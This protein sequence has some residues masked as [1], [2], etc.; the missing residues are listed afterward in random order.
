MKPIFSVIPDSVSESTSSRIPIFIGMGTRQ[1]GRIHDWIS[2][3]LLGR[4]QGEE[5]T[6]QPGIAAKS[7]FLFIIL[8]LSL[9]P[10][11]LVAQNPT[12]QWVKQMGGPSN[13]FGN[14]ITTDVNGNLYTTGSFQ[15][16]VD[17][18]PGTG[19][20]NLTSIGNQDIFIQK[21]DSDGNFVW[22][23]QMG[24]TDLGFGYAITTDANGNILTTGYFKGTV[25]FDPGTGTHSFTSAGND[26]FIQKLDANGAFVWAKQMSGIS[27]EEGN[28]I[29][30]DATGNVYI[31]GSFEGTVDFDPGTGTNELSS[32]GVFDIFVQKLDADGAFVWAKSMGGP[33]FDTGYSLTTDANGNVYTTGAF[34][35]GVDFD[36]GPGTTAFTSAG[37]D[38]IFIQKLDPNGEFIWAKQIGG[39]GDDR[40]FSITL[41]ANGHVYTTGAFEGTADFDPGA[42]T[43]DLTS[44]GSA[45]I[46][47]QKLDA[48]GNLLWVKQMGG[49][50]RDWG[51]S[52]VIDANGNVY[53]TGHFLSRADFDPGAG[54]TQ[55]TSA[56]ASDIFVQKLD[57]NGDFVWA[58]Q[59]GGTD[60]DEGSSLTLDANGNIYTT[61]Y[62]EGTAD[63]DPGVG[64]SFLTSA[65]FI[66]FPDIFIHK[67]STTTVGLSE[68]AL[69]TRFIVY[70]NPTKGTISIEFENAQESVTLRLLSL[71]GQVIMTQRSSYTHILP[72]SFSQPNGVYILEIV[73][74]EAN[75]AVVRLLKE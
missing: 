74:D 13:D 1:Q 51:K 67:L 65:G 31:T 53:S 73:D 30:T 29:T 22:A 4:G 25:D 50:G 39:I 52:L 72:L 42:G 18:D 27:Q 46:F 21:L 63:F 59:M 47:I 37:N 8:L 36:P 70:P 64:T 68:N 11:S 35:G 69:S 6:A 28:S 10:S 40:G 5:Q 71:S 24:G 33:M 57:A 7:S 58:E 9:F 17:F 49:P 45:D 3:F 75:K 66:G 41:D 26:I 44:A 32:A 16:T 61:G 2:N 54:T 56:G 60:Y 62:F 12:F 23:K 34:E 38:D 20:S 15:G 14:S 55:L 19:I 43:T 48:N